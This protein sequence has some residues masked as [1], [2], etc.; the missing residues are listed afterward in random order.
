MLLVQINYREFEGRNQEWV[1]DGLTLGR[2][3]LLVGKNATGKSRTLNVIGGLA[4]L[5]AGNMRP[6]LLSASYSAHFEDGPKHLS[7]AFR[8]EDEKVITETFSV[9][10]RILL[11]RAQGRPGRI[12][13][14]EIDGG[15]DIL[16]QAPPNDLAAVLRRDA[17]Q[18]P[19]LQPLHDWGTSVRHYYFGTS[20]GKENYAI[21]PK[22]LHAG[23]EADDRDGSQ[24]VAIYRKAVHELGEGTIKRALVTDLERVG[25]PI[26]DLGIG[27]PVSIR[28]ASQLPGELLGF[29]VREKGLKAITD[30]HTMSQ[31]MFRV[32]AL[33][34]L[35]NYLT[36]ARK[37]GC[38]LIDDIG[39]GLDFDRSCLLIDLLR[40]KAERSTVQLIVS[41]N[42]KFV[43]NRVPLEEWSV[44]QRRGSRLRVLNYQNS[45]DLFE[46][47]R[48]TGLS[49]FSFLEM[50]FASGGPAAEAP[51]HE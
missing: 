51:V 15:K 34:V 16:F 10:E 45:R 2:R 11:D 9:S 44:L 14:Q 30:Q 7:Y 18:H 38:I 32:L 50:D 37:A 42:D 33:V 27:P 19:F 12:F 17:I 13:A 46:E 43:M 4:R 25:Y 49:N 5:L 35:A 40:E 20:L 28:L 24:V 23:A 8:A 22:G 36:L 31:G 29:W 26:D 6:T 48:F 41:T 39:E 3:N 1:L 21:V 47:F